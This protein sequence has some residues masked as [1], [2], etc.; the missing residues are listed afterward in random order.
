MV[1]FPNK[2][3]AVVDRKS[4]VQL[5][6]M[7]NICWNVLLNGIIPSKIMDS[8][9]NLG[10]FIEHANTRFKLAWLDVLEIRKTP[11]A[12]ISQGVVVAYM[13]AKSRRD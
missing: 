12:D 3:F 2:Y 1:L 4:D 6:V 8:L 13:A 7:S 11:A 5:W 10:Y 9:C